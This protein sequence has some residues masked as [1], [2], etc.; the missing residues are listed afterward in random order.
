MSFPRAFGGNPDL[1]LD[2]LQHHSG[3]TGIKNYI[4]AVL[5]SIDIRYIGDRYLNPSGSKHN[6]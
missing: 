4:L 3:T 2:A 6:A 1:L 5:C